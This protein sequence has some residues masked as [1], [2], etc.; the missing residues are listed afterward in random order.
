VRSADELIKDATDAMTE[1]NAREAE[2]KAR[3]LADRIVRLSAELTE[4]KKE[5]KSLTY[6]EVT[7]L[8]LGL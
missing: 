5:L 1:E 2:R 4:A 7:P 8:D 6:R 3:N